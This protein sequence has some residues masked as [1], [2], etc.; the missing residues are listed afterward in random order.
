[1]NLQWR[2]R[3]LEWTRA[4]YVFFTITFF[5]VGVTC[6]SFALPYWA[7]VNLS[8]LAPN[9]AFELEFQLLGYGD[10]Y[11]AEVLLDNVFVSDPLGNILIDFEDAS[12]P[13]G[14]FTE[15]GTNAL[16]TVNN[17]PGTLDGTGSKVL[18]LIED[19]TGMQLTTIVYQSFVPSVPSVLKFDYETL[20]FETGFLGDDQFTV[21]LRDAFNN[22]LLSPGVLGVGDPV[23]LDVAPTSGIRTNSYTTTGVIP[24]PTTILLFAAG[25]FGLF[26]L[27]RK[28][29]KIK[30]ALKN[31]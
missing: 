3:L 20:R 14:G 15:A 7:T 29:L 16:G 27:G 13:L 21:R 8:S 23:V 30:K 31:G 18:S 24:E 11:D 5:V 17:V 6:S 12:D 25:I 22:P 19:S 9:T 1:M 10:F 2:H 4:M 26:G 28:G